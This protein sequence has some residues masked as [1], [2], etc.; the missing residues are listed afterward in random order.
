MLAATNVSAQF[1]LYKEIDSLQFYTKW[2]H[3]KWYSK[4]SGDVLLV[5]VVNTSSSTAELSVGVEFFASMKL[6]EESQVY[7]YCVEAGK[8]L[9]PRVHGLVF[10]PASGGKENFESFELKDPDITKRGTTQCPKKD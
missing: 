9:K 8:T 10:Q 1:Q 3:A 2:S 5:K 7:S 4:K 6:V